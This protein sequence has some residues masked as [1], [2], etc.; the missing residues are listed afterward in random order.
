MMVNQKLTRKAICDRAKRI[1]IKV[2]SSVITAEGGVNLNVIDGLSDEI[3]FLKAGGREVVLISSG[4]IASGIKK[5]GIKRRLASLSEQQ[6]AAAIGQGGLIQ[7]YE[8]GFA[9]YGQHVAQI[10]ITRDDLAN[11]YR[12]LNARNTLFTLLR[13]GVIP[14]INENDTVA[15]EE[16][17]F[18]DNDKIA[19]LITGIVE[20]DLLILL[21]DIDGL[22]DKDPRIHPD[23]HHLPLVERIDQKIKKLA[24]SIPGR[25][26]RGGMAS[27]IQIIKDVTRLGIPVFIANGREPLIL[28]KIFS[29]ENVGTLFL[30]QSTHFP[31]RKHWISSLKPKGELVIDA[32]AVKALVYNRKSLLPSG[33]KLVR[34]VFQ[35]GDP[36]CCVDENRRL[37]GIGLVNYASSDI[38]KIK[39]LKTSEISRVLGF[40]NYDEVIHRDNLYVIEPD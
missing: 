3:S 23:A 4:A 12:Y 1:V 24:N 27:K 7:A 30:P 18:G 39:G 14:I 32:G 17:Q 36:V 28:H 20:A 6:A 26:G 29:G 19:A 11:R 9:K 10:L 21:T 8:E 5:M 31:I 34:G 16:I 40:K 25:F 37:I 35:V 15:V 22:Y 2:G 13:W 38:E 33:I